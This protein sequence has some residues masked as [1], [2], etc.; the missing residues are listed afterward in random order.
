MEKHF[1]KSAY[2][3][4]LIEHLFIGELRKLSWVEGSCSIEIAKPE[5][6]SQGYDLMAEENGVIRHSMRYC[7]TMHNQALQKLQFTPRSIFTC[8]LSCYAP[9]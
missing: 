8:E 4:K 7:L 3:E 5:V 6:D 1:L 2:R 9:S